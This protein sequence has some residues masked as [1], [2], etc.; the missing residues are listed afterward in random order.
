VSRG[1]RQSAY[2]LKPLLKAV[3]IFYGWGC[4]LEPLVN[5]ASP[6]FAVCHLR[7]LALIC[8]SPAPSASPVNRAEATTSRLWAGWSVVRHVDTHNGG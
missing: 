7:T 2:A 5:E 4:Q 6:R 3:P 1:N 8:P